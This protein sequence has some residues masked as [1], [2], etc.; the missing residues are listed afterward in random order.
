MALGALRSIFR[1]PA[2]AGAGTRKQTRA[3]HLGGDDG[4]R[5]Q[6][7]EAGHLAGR[8]HADL[9]LAVAEQAH[10]VGRQVAARVLGAQR[11]GQLGELVGHVVAHAPRLVRLLRIVWARGGK[12]RVEQGD[13]SSA[14]APAFDQCDVHAVNCRLREEEEEV[15]EERGGRRTWA[16]LC[17]S[18]SRLRTASSR[19]SA[20]ANAP[21]LSTT[22][23]RTESWSARQHARHKTP[24]CQ[25]HWLSPST[26]AGA[27]TPL[28]S[29]TCCCCLLARQGKQR[30]SQLKRFM[31]EQ[32][33]RSDPNHH[34]HAC[35][36]A[37]TVVGEVG[38]ELHELPGH[39]LALHHPGKAAQLLRRRA[40]HHG[41]LV[42]AQRG[43]E[44]A[45]LGAEAGRGAG[46]G[47]GEEAR[48]RD[49]R[50][51]PL[52]RGQPLRA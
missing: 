12:R 51:E 27:R 7:A 2:P 52:A 37:R 15:E 3:A 40:A 30:T 29:V 13:G 31:Q 44:R 36:D 17:T 6:L 50:G 28:R 25:R 39:V 33:Q 32:Q 46:V 48:R 23:S 41:R 47:C 18:G 24:R 20:P 10:K 22:S 19:P 35:A 49:A 45:Q 42:L 34:R 8:R 26:R 11:L 1:P 21:V 16:N 5:E 43:K 14:R 9:G 38:E 4:R